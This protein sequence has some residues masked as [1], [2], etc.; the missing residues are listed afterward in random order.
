MAA[1][2][3]NLVFDTS[4]RFAGAMAV[5]HVADG[6]RVTRRVDRRTFR[7]RHRHGLE[8]G[9]TEAQAILWRF[10]AVELQPGE[11]RIVE[12]TVKGPRPLLGAQQQPPFEVVGT[13][14]ASG[15][16]IS[17]RGQ[18]SVNPPLQKFKLPATFAL[19]AV[20]LAATA[21]AVRLANQPEHAGKTIGVVLPDSGERYLSS[22][23]FEGVFDDKGLAR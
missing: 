20:V 22:A 17:A 12:F 21:V 6:V 23:L 15:A 4:A 7:Y 19:L 10:A 5:E 18:L 14:S 9:Q 2:A 3:A 11:K 1:T 8:E 13:S 16:E